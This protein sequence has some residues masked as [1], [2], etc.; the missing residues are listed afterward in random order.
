VRRHEIAV[1]SLEG[2]DD[3]AKTKERFS[4]LIVVA[5]ADGKLIDAAGTRHPHAGPGGADAAAPMTVLIDRDGVVKW[6]FRPD[7]F[8][9]RLS[10]EEVLSAVDSHLP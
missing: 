9:E 7:R 2:Q 1:V 4:H 6:L 10:P 3:A 8:T 5:D